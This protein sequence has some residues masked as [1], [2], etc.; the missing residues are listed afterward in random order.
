MYIYPLLG[1]SWVNTFPQ[2]KILGQQQ[3]KGFALPGNGLVDNLHLGALQQ[4]QTL[5][6]GN[7]K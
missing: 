4:Y 2:R 5:L 7:K 1:N 3:A 6:L